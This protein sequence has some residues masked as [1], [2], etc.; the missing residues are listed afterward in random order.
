MKAHLALDTPL[1]PLHLVAENGAL[2][3]AWFDGQKHFPEHSDWQ[4]AK[5]QPVLTEAAQ[6]LTEFFQGKRQHFT[7]PLAPKGTAFQQQVWQGLRQIPFGQTCSY[8]ELAKRLGKPSAVRAVAAANGRNPLSVIVPC[9]RVIG[10]NGQLTGYAGGL[11]RKAWLLDL[12][13]KGI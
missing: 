4:T 7:L 9:H 2:I 11:A 3:G 10:A 13:N 5:A 1:G 12:E 6:Q 8:G